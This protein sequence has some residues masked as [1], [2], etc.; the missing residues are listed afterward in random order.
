M[1]L[2]KRSS[3]NFQENLFGSTSNSLSHRC[4]WGN[5]KMWLN[6][7]CCDIATMSRGLGRGGGGGGDMI[8]YDSEATTITS[9]GLTQL[10]PNTKNAVNK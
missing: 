6:C 5:L 4:N 7:F 1:R 3:M 2:I 8:S 10:H 9:V